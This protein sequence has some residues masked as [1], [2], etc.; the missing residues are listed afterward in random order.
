MSESAIAT[1]LSDLFQPEFARNPFP[2][3]AALRQEP[4]VQVTFP[5]GQRFWLVTRYQDVLALFKDRRF[6]NDYT[7][8]L[9]LESIPELMRSDRSIVTLDG[10]DH[11]RLRRLVGQAFTPRLVEQM[12]PRVQQIT[13]ELLD[14]VIDA[15]QM[16]LVNDFAFPL[17]MTVILE[18]LGVPVEDRERCRAGSNALLLAIDRMGATPSPELLA[19]LEDFFGYISQ[20]IATKRANPQD[21]LLSALIQA[22]EQEDKLSEQELQELLR[23]LI[24]AGHETTV[25]LISLGTL[26]LLTN[27]A[28]LERLR[29]NPEQIPAAVEELLRLESVVT[30]SGARYATEDIELGGQLIPRGDALLPLVASA[31]HDPTQFPHPSRFDEANIEGHH[32]AFGH[33]AHYCLGAPLARLE[34]QIAFATLLRRLPNLHLSDAPDALVWANNWSLRSL[35]RMLV[36]F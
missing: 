35:K 11:A 31:N 5:N 36:E 8:F 28:L 14:A 4:P 1:V 21:D 18:T 15:G 20:L 7:R 29:D 25:S 3:Y 13:D 6:S 17:P 23:A 22:H 10:E 2:I 33:G 9:D 24:I 27:R 16:D 19:Q 32:L 30:A 34:G 26:E 12:R